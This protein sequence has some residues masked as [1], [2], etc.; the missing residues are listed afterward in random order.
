[1]RILVLTVNQVKIS[2][3]FEGFNCEL[4]QNFRFS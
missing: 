4:G 3:N 2:D 1:M